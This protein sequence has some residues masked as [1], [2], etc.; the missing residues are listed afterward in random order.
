M[1]VTPH[2]AS[3][4]RGSAIDARTTR[5]EGYAVSQRKRK[6]IEEASGWGKTIGPIAQLCRRAA[7]LCLHPEW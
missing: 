5:H 6:L 4:A 1:C 2:I 3:K 7:R